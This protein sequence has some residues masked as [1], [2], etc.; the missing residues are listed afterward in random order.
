[1]ER[2][3]V[4]EAGGPGLYLELL[5]GSHP[6]GNAGDSTLIIW[7]AANNRRGSSQEMWKL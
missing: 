7:T 2:P 1:M 3:K 6:R 5:K 4:L